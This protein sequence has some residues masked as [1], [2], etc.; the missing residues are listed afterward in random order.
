MQGRVHYYEGYGMKDVV[1]PV[2][3]LGLMGAKALFLTN[4]AGGINKSF[5]AG[6][7]MLL[8]DHIS[9]FVPSPLA[10]EN[11]NELGARFPDMTEV[12]SNELRK[13][14][15]NTAKNIGINLHEGVY[16]QL[17]G[18]A[19]ETPAEIRAL[20][21]LGADAVGMSTACEAIAARHMGLLV[22]GVS[23][24]SNLAAGISETPLSHDEVKKAA[25]NAAPRFC[26]LIKNSVIEIG[27]VL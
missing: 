19:Y 26:A 21:L 8:R 11:D 24:I 23:L 5:T 3:I 16:A 4:A 25:E 10:G 17:P 13:I 27:N 20:S 2:R 18:P 12:Y 15:K 1:M 14:I 6:D 22:C 9:F 7:F